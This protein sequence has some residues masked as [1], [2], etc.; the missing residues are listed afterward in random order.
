MPSRLP[1]RNNHPMRHRRTQQWQRCNAATQS[2][3][4]VGAGEHGED[5]E[6]PL[7]L[8]RRRSFE[9]VDAIGRRQR[10]RHRVPRHLFRF[11]HLHHAVHVDDG[12][13]HR[14]RLW[15][16]P[17]HQNQI[18]IVNKWEGWG[19]IITAPFLVCFL[20]DWLD[21]NGIPFSRALPA[22]GFRFPRRL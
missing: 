20:S 17:P 12:L 13:R 21:R 6:P 7:G 3:L 2:D 9:E 5:V 4:H 11:R 15:I 10:Q 22:S 18:I 8:L 16:P 1:N 14:F 19:Q